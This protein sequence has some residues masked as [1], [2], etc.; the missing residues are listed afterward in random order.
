M[1]KKNFERIMEGLNDAAAIAEGRA[2]P[3]T[4]RLHPPGAVDVR[5]IR[6]SQG[7][8]Q[9][10]FAARYGFTLGRLRDWE[11]GRTEPDPTSRILLKVIEKEPGAITRALEA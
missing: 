1:A 4:F 11:Q 9:A 8:T 6:R 3:T 7:L 10:E 5:G 2:D